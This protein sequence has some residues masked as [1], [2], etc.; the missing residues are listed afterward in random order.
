[1]ANLTCT[2]SIRRFFSIPKTLS[3]EPNLRSAP[4]TFSRFVA[5]F[6]SAVP[7]GFCCGGFSST[8]GYVPGN[9]AQGFAALSGLA[10]E[11]LFLSNGRR[12]FLSE[13]LEKS[14]DLS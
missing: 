11:W 3:G 14:F 1:L 12:P 9:E 6:N 8:A 10:P 13:R 2:R 4:K 5:L 7:L